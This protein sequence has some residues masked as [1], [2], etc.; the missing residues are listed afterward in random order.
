MKHSLLLTVHLIFICHIF[1]NWEFRNS[2]AS[3]PLHAWVG[4][5]RLKLLHPKRRTIFRIDKSEVHLR[6]AEKCVFLELSALS[7]RTYVAGLYSMAYKSIDLCV[8]LGG[9]T[10]ILALISLSLH[11]CIMHSQCH[12]S[13]PLKSDCLLS[14]ARCTDAFCT[15][16][17]KTSILKFYSHA[18]TPHLLK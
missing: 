3:F 13:A 7:N 4:R 12:L 1:E 6:N 16:Q 18:D 14:L 9:V 8:L 15:F 5:Q 2:I 10:F 11:H 17:F